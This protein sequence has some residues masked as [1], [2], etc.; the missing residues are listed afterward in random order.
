MPTTQVR[1]CQTCKSDEPHRHLTAE[2]DKWLRDRRGLKDT[3]STHVWW[4]CTR[5]GCRTMR[6][7]WDNRQ[8]E[9]LPPPDES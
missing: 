7:Y 4:R 5:E 3:D 1:A 2:E 8:W 6:H 9:Q